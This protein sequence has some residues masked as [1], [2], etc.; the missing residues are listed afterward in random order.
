MPAWPQRPCD[1][2]IRLCKARLFRGD[3]QMDKYTRST[4]IRLGERLHGGVVDPDGG[5]ACMRIGVAHCCNGMLSGSQQLCEDR[6]ALSAGGTVDD[7][8]HCMLLYERLEG[9]RRSMGG[10]HRLLQLH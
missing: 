5:R 6:G 9:W 10:V 8:G 1:D 4:A 2:G 3:R 7:V